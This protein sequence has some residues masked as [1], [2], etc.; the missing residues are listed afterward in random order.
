[1]TKD[2]KR[3]VSVSLSPC[4]GFAPRSWHLMWSIIQPVMWNVW[5]AILRSSYRNG[6]SYYKVQCRR[7]G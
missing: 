3:Y 4:A 7:W 1:M 5:T 2:K 6:M